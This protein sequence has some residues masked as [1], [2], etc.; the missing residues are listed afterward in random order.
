MAVVSRDQLLKIGALSKARCDTWRRLACSTHFIFKA[1]LK[2]RAAAQFGELRQLCRA[3]YVR[4]VTDASAGGQ[5][6]LVLLYTDAIQCHPMM[7]PWAEAAR[8]F[9]NIK[10]MKGVASEIIED[11]PD[12]LTPTVIMYKDKECVKQVQGLAEWGGCDMSVDSIERVL[13]ELGVVVETV[14]ED[15]Q[16]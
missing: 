13:A 4:E 10:F 16:E 9:P 14:L 8:R 5:W 3:S 2:A 15:M 1:E 6:V 12:H 11:F 7:R